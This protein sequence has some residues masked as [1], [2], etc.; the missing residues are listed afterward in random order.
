MIKY[1]GTRF[2]IY[3]FFLLI[4]LTGVFIGALV[5]GIIPTEQCENIVLPLKKTGQRNYGVIFSKSF[6]GCIKPVLFMWVLGFSGIAVY[7]N[8][9]AVVYKGGVLGVALGAFMKIYGIGKGM[10][11]SACGILPQ[12][13]VFVP[14]LMYVCIATFEF[15]GSKQKPKRK[16]ANYV[17][18]LVIA[19]MGCLFT[20]LMDTYVTSLLLRLCMNGE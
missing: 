2:K 13:F 18:H 9:L 10:L 5:S 3:L 19:L 17:L 15:S 4:L 8:M 6:F 14:V 12:Y 16:F 11:I 7:C 20:A 1:R